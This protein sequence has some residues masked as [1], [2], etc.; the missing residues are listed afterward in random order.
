MSSLGM[1][2]CGAWRVHTRKD[3]KQCGLCGRT[4]LLDAAA[5]LEAIADNIESLSDE[6]ILADAE[7]T[8][9]NVEAE[10]ERIKEVLLQPIQLSLFGS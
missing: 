2:P 5:I 3:H 1:C 6:E 7:A 9:V 8:G 10:A 4:F